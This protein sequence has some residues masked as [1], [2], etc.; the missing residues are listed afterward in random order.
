MKD[1]ISKHSE[2]C[3]SWSLVIQCMVQITWH[4]LYIIKCNCQHF[5]ASLVAQKLKRLLPMRETWVRS[6]GLED[7]LEKEMVTHSSI[8]ARRIP[9]TEKPGRLQSMG[10]QRVGHDWANKPGIVCSL[11]KA[12][13]NILKN[14]ILKNSVWGLVLL[15]WFLYLVLAWWA[16]DFKNQQD[17]FLSISSPYKRKGDDFSTS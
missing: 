2:Q 15:A 6:L 7:P 12:T 10:S 5:K 3:C 11:L 17:K 13:V 9:W 1:F 16:S 14:I 4:C 8:L